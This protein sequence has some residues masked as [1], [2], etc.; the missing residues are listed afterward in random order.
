MT[1]PRRSSRPAPTRL[2]AGLALAALLAHAHAATITIVNNDGAGEGFNDPTVVSPVGGNPGTTLGAQRLNAFQFAA[3]IW[4][5]QLTSSVTIF[6]DATMDPLFCD[7]TSA[8]LGQAG[9]SS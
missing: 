2:A 6:V 9:A 8:T 5:A 7:S 1:S 4:G 3:N